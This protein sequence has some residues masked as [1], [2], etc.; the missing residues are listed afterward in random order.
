[1]KLDQAHLETVLP[2]IGK[3][4]LI[5]NGAYRGEQAI[6]ENI[7]PDDFCAKVSIACVSYINLKKLFNEKNLKE[8]FF[9]RV[10]LKEE[11]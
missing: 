7:Y 2:A 4:V 1:M 6:M 9:T 8:F 3:K 10:L 11:L 5:L